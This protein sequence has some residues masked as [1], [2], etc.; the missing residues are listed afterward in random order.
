MGLESL[1]HSNASPHKHGEVPADMNHE[2]LLAL[3]DEAQKRG[4]LM[5]NAGLTKQMAAQNPQVQKDLAK[6]FFESTIGS[7]LSTQTVTS[8]YEVYAQLKGTE[9]SNTFR[10]LESERLM[11]AGYSPLTL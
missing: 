3:L 5:P 1:P 6:E 7:H 4:G 8:A 9:F 2:Q 10:E 11:A